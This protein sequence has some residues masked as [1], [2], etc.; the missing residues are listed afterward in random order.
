MKQVER[1]TGAEISRTG[2]NEIEE[3]RTAVK[4][5]EEESGLGLG[6]RGFDPLKARPD[7]AIVAAPFA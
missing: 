1:Y 2:I 7:G 4:F 5:G 6:I 3:T